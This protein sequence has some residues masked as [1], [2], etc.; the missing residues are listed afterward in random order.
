METEM[1][2]VAKL[3]TS[4]WHEYNKYI[5]LLD[6]ETKDIWLPIVYGCMLGKPLNDFLM[7]INWDKTDLDG[8]MGLQI[9]PPCGEIPR[10]VM[11]VCYHAKRLE[12]EAKTT[13]LPDNAQQ[14]YMERRA[15][16]LYGKDPLSVIEMFEIDI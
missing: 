2:T 6:E 5:N 16:L 4:D 8:S 14:Q 11:L 13:L 9:Y 3:Y 15:E 10:D 1:D 12:P 7:H